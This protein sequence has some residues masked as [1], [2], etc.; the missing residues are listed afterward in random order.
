MQQFSRD[1][2]QLMI[3]VMLVIVSVVL[4]SLGS[5]IRC[6]SPRLLYEQTQS[7]ILSDPKMPS[8]GFLYIFAG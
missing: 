4:P 7:Q 6:P 5:E 8:L 2:W 1:Y 3:T